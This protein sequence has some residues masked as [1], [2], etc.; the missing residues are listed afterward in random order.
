MPH[1]IVAE[2]FAFIVHISAAS[3]A[4]A[5]GAFQMI[6]TTRNKFLKMHRWIGR[7]YALS[8][9]IGGIS[10]LWIALNIDSLIALIGFALLAA[11]WMFT[12]TKAVLFARSKQIKQHRK[13]MI[14]SFSLTFAA[15]TL[16]LQLAVFTFGMGLQYGAVDMILAWSCWVPNILFALWY[17]R[18]G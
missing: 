10:G 1:Q 6:K 8:V 13:W 3:V 12:T 17:T 9:A 15:V 16:R 7:I 18:A 2:H 4:L 14:Y 11:L 5:L